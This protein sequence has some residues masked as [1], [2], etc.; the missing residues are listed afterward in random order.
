MVMEGGNV[1]H[2]VKREGE[3]Y[4]VGEISVVICPG[5][6]SGFLCCCVFDRDATTPL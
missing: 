4:G 3:L 5:E 2:H 6:M 1:L